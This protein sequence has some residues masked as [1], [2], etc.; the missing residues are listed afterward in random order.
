PGETVT[1]SKLLKQVGYK[2][3][4]IGKWGLGG[5]DSTGH[6]NRQGFDHFFGYLGQSQAHEYYPDH[7]WRNDQKVPLDGKTYS[8]DL[9]TEEALDF[10]RAGKDSP[11][12]LYIPYT[13]P[14]TKFQVPDLGQYAE[15]PWT[16]DQKTQ[17]AMI[18]R[19]DRDIGRIINLL[20]ELGIDDNTVM[21]FT[22]D[23]G[24]HGSS[25]TLELFNANGPLRGIKRDV[26]EGGIRV[27][28]IARWPGRIRGGLVTDHIS[29]FWDLLPTCCEL[30]GGE[31][32][33]SID[34]IS[35]LPTLLSS[36]DRQKQHEYLYWEFKS[37]GGKQA[38]RMGRWKGVR[39]N[40]RTDPN[41]PLELYDLDDDIGETTEIAGANPQI[42]S[43]IEQR[44]A[45]AHRYS[46]YFPLLYGE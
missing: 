13:I 45:Q 8:H 9:M 15:M 44:M 40:V 3:G 19:M 33:A 21:F 38:L 31:I 32:P 29:A 11:F 6:P 5:P 30:A 37:R 2:C 4:C 42:V 28:F 25:G 20:K 10:I 17:A 26:Y 41:P 27:P 23:N 18:S 46:S 12:F 24:P 34:G 1:V 43:Q 14:H 35:F 39:L 22:S 16:N 7:L 36:P